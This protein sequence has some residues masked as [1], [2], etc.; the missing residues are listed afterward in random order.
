MKV[1][2][3]QV[4]KLLISDLMGEPHKLDPV[5]VILEDYAPGKGRIIIECYGKSWSSYW[6][7]MGKESIAQFFSTCSADYLIGNLDPQLQ[8]GR[9]SGDALVDLARKTIIS[10]RTDWR[11]RDRSFTC[12]DKEDCRR[13]YDQSEELGWHGSIDQAITLDFELLKEVFDTNE[14]WHDVADA[15]KPNPDYL[16]L[17]RIVSAVQQALRQLEAPA[18]AA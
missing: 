11:G 4:T 10:R 12:L 16:Y 2:S 13:L 1:E 8:A 9:F 5:T 14:P 15:T 17:E 18:E 6:G 3:T 7:A